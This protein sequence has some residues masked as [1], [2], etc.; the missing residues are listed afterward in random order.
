MEKWT[1]KIAV[2]TGA[3]SGIGKSISLALARAGLKVFGLARR[4]E[5]LDEVQ[6]EAADFPGSFVGIQCDISNTKSIEEAFITIR[7]KVDKI[8]ILINN[9]G[10]GLNATVLDA[11][12]THQDFLDIFNVIFMGTV[13]CTREAFNSMKTHKEPRYI[14]NMNS[15]AGHSTP[16]PL[17]LPSNVYPAATHAVTNH[18]ELLRLQF[19]NSEENLSYNDI[20]VT[21]SSGIL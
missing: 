8:H 21:V 11:S 16:N 14:I 7:G 20:R 3:S 18:T 13:V 5:R 6:T 12:K 10:S 4:R 17:L 2:V 15:I 1:G 9:A 19:A